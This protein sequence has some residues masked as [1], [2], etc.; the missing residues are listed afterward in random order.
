VSAKVSRLA[1]CRPLTLLLNAVGG[2]ADSRPESIWKG[3]APRPDEAVENC[4]AVD[5]PS[6]RL[7]GGAGRSESAA[8]RALLA[9]SVFVGD[10]AAE[11]KV[12]WPRGD[13]GGDRIGLSEMGEGGTN[14]KDSRMESAREAEVMTEESEILRLGRSPPWA[15]ARACA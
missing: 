4:E 14:G 15:C 13:T 3:N 11:L 1:R 8:A 2:F 6:V 7:L 5:S 9:N 12:C 10:G